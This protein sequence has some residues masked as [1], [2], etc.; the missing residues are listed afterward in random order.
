MAYDIRFRTRVLA[1]VD[2][3]HTIRETAQL[4]GI[5]PST[6]TYWFRLQRETGELHDSPRETRHKK[7]DPVKLIAYFE[8]TPDSYL[9]EAAEAFGCSAVAIYKARKRLGLTRKKNQTFCGKL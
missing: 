6:I 3:G 5:S 7:I 1:H 2:M 9:S 8:E 4:F